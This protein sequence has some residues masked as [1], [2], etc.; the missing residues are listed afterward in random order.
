MGAVGAAIT[1]QSDS[2]MPRGGPAAAFVARRFILRAP[3]LP[4]VD[5]FFWG[6]GGRRKGRIFGRTLVPAG[7]GAGVRA[8]WA[9]GRGSNGKMGKAKFV[10]F[11]EFC[12]FL[13]PHG[14]I[15]IVFGKNWQPSYGRTLMLI[16]FPNA[17]FTF[18]IRPP[19][20]R[21]VGTEGLPAPGGPAPPTVV[22]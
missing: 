11:V 5:N 19:E 21:R 12:L 14:A 16:T 17:L 22:D 4:A 18:P 2:R 15:L 6:I 9:S 7:H 10:V 20:S 13:S 1:R 8:D 3:S